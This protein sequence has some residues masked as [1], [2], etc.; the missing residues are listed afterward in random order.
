MVSGLGIKPGSHLK[1]LLKNWHYKN[2]QLKFFL[3][4]FYES[5]NTYPILCYIETWKEYLHIFETFGKTDCYAKLR[6]T[7]ITA[8]KLLKCMPKSIMK[9]KSVSRGDKFQT[10]VLKK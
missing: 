1:I 9:K 4:N 2:M 3:A 10:H 5:Y 7:L 6:H 8:C